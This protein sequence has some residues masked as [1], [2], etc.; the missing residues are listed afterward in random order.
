MLILNKQFHYVNFDGLLS[1]RIHFVILFSCLLERRYVVVGDV[2]RHKR[3]ICFVGIVSVSRS[4][5]GCFLGVKLDVF[6]FVVGAVAVDGQGD[7][8]SIRYKG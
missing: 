2:A 4:I 3:H 1:A 6:T 7:S 5:L 8:V